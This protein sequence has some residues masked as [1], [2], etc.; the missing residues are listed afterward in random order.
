MAA[1]GD[2]SCHCAK[3]LRYFGVFGQAFFPIFDVPNQIQA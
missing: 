2:T 3:P 1:S